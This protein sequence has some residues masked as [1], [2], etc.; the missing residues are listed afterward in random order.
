MLTGWLWSGGRFGDADFEVFFWGVQ[1]YKEVGGDVISDV[2]VVK[3]RQDL[4]L[5]ESAEGVSRQ[6][7]LEGGPG[8]ML[9]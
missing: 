4:V 2:K 6:E 7:R 5:S 8:M 1:R 9:N 3:G